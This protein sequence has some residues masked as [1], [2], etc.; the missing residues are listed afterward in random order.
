M[1][2]LSQDV[3]QKQGGKRKG[4]KKQRQDKSQDTTDGNLKRSKKKGYLVG[5]KSHLE[6]CPNW[7][8]WKF[9]VQIKVKLVKKNEDQSVKEEKSV[10][11][12]GRNQW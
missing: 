10:K 6:S 3:S 8:D 5:L 4:G 2:I 11:V 7:P 1:P 9:S 12:Q